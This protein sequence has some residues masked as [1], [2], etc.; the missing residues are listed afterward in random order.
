MG[1]ERSGW[2]RLFPLTPALSPGERENR[3]QRLDKSGALEYGMGCDEFPIDKFPYSSPS[4][5]TSHRFLGDEAQAYP[6]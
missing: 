4:V 3:S 2:G 6:L 1:I 5:G